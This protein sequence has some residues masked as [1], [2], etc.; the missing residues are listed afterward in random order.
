MPLCAY[1]EYKGILILCKAREPSNFSLVTVREHVDKFEALEN[2][3][4]VKFSHGSFTILEHPRKKYLLLDKLHQ[5]IPQI[6]SKP[7]CY[8][9]R[10]F[11]FQYD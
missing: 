9:R 4:K 8:F 11:L 1:Y 5:L 2:I 3:I 10:E 7:H 6:P